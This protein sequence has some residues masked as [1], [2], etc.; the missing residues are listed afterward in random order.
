MLP[1]ES[2][3]GWVGENEHFLHDIGLH[4]RAQA[5]SQARLVNAALT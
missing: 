1:P 3:I 5:R 4:G 2:R